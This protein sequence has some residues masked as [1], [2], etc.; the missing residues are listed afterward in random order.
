[1]KFC[2]KYN[3]FA[4]CLSALFVSTSFAADT[5]RVATY[6][7]ENYLDQ[8]TESRPHVKSAEARNQGP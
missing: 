3:C 7:V 2:V 4:I 8:P 1:M 5:F 6:N